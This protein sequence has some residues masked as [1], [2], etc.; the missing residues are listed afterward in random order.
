M[1]WL[2]DLSSWAYWGKCIEI[3]DVFAFTC[4]CVLMLMSSK[5]HKY[6]VISSFKKLEKILVVERRRRGGVLG[7]KEQI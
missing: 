1:D 6:R 4:I 3:D 7:A 5:C 2:F